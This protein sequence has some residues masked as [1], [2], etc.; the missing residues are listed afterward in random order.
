MTW[1]RAMTTHRHLVALA[2]GLAL[3]WFLCGHS[4]AAGKPNF[5]FILGEGHGW[6]STSVLM[7]DAVP[8]SKSASVRTPNFA[9]LARGGMKFMHTYTVSSPNKP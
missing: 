4:V 1:R 7:D 5:V 2:S 6:S 3:L 9:R 8:A